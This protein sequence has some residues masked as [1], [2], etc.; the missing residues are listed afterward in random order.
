MTCEIHPEAVTMRCYYIFGLF[1]VCTTADVYKEKVSVRKKTH[2]YKLVTVLPAAASPPQ[3]IA[4]T[5]YRATDAPMHGKLRHSSHAVRYCGNFA[6][7]YLRRESH[8]AG[9]AVALPRG[10]F[11]HR[12]HARR[13]RELPTYPG[14]RAGIL[15]GPPRG[16][17]FH[18]L[19]LI[20][21]A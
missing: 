17:S 1:F 2:C 6:R 11:I 14:L 3:F 9:P 13:S 10:Y 19:N 21:I 4:V 16:T 12:F 8:T 18:L 20:T 15:A 5:V 7:W